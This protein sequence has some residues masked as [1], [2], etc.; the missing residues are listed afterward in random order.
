MKM[1]VFVNRFYPEEFRR[2]SDAEKY[3]SKGT[4]EGSVAKNIHLATKILLKIKFVDSEFLKRSLMNPTNSFKWRHY[5]SEIILLC[6][7]WYLRYCLSYRNLE[8]MMNERGL[9]VDHTTIYRWVQLYGAELKKK[10]RT[11]VCQRRFNFDPPLIKIAGRKLT[12]LYKKFHS[13]GFLRR[14]LMS[15]PV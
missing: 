10:L 12:H 8:E 1:Q 4:C 7:R 5:S 9:K 3:H 14:S 6:V 2:K 13:D 11:F 15:A